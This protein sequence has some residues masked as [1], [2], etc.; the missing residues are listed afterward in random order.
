MKKFIIGATVAFMTIGFSTSLASASTLD[1]NGDFVMNEFEVATQKTPR[2][3]LWNVIRT[4]SVS[5]TSISAD[6]VAKYV[7]TTTDYGLTKGKNVKQ[8]H[9]RIKEGN[10]DSGRKYSSAAKSKSDGTRYSTGTIS[11]VNNPLH[12]AYSYNGWLYF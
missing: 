3:G 9:V 2:M 12:T 5:K 6:F 11:K 8:A 1:S 4:N 7:T 10:Y